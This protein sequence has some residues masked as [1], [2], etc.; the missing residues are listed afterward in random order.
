MGFRFK[1]ED[2][3]FG[4]YYDTTDYYKEKY[5]D[6]QYDLSKFVKDYDNIDDILNKIKI[7]IMIK[8]DKV[9]ENGDLAI[10]YSDVCQVIDK[11]YKNKARWCKND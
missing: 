8:C 11:Y 6:A 7:E 2:F 5:E 9:A 1:K 10:T 4:T 3:K